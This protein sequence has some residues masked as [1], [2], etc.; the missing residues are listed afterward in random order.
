MDLFRCHQGNTGMTMLF[1]IPVEKILTKYSGILN[2]A[3]PLRELRTI[4]QCFE[5]GFGVR[6]VVANMRAAVGFGYPQIAEKMRN[7][8]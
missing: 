1:V 2:R 4:L 3:E 7:H 5:L 6:V 8:L